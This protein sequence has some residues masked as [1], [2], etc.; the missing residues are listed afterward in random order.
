MKWRQCMSRKQFDKSIYSFGLFL[1]Y[2][3]KFQ[4]LLHSLQAWLYQRSHHSKVSWLTLGFVLVLCFGVTLVILWPV[5]FQRYTDCEPAQMTDDF[6]NVCFS[7]VLAPQHEH[8]R[9]PFSQVSSIW[10]TWRQLISSQE[11]H[12]TLWGQCLSRPPYESTVLGSNP[13]CNTC[14]FCANWWNPPLLLI[15]SWS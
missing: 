11:S 10:H 1:S 13:W 6:C 2:I 14:P 8:C 4:S 9:G 15:L 5:C 3:D 7:I 12:R